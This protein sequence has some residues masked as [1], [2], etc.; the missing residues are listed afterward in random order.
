MNISIIINNHRLDSS[1]V[2]LNFLHLLQFRINQC[3]LSTIHCLKEETL[4]K[5]AGAPMPHLVVP[6]DTT[7]TTRYGDRGES[8]ARSPPPLSP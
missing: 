2:G 3:R 1:F 5:N 7:P 6:P 4:V 8:R